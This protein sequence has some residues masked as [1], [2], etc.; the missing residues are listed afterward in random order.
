M[1]KIKYLYSLLAACPATSVLAETPA[2][3]TL[4]PIVVTATRT[5]TKL[6]EVG[7]SITVIN[8][9]ELARR[10]QMPVS[11]ILRG[12]PGLDV[13]RTGGAGQQVSV[14][15]RGTNSN[16]SLVLINGI[17][18]NDPASPGAAFDFANLLTDNIERIEIL[19]GPQ[20]VLYGSDAIG[21]VINIITKKGGGRPQFSLQG[22]GG[23]FDTY[24]FGG[25]ASGGSSLLNYAVS[26]SHLE[27]AGISSATA[28]RG[29]TEHD[30]YRN[31]TVDA[32]FG[33]TPGEH[34]ELDATL[35]YN[36][37]HVELDGS[38]A[39]GQ[40]TDDPNA[41]QDAEQ[42]FARGQARLNLF[43]DRWQQILGLSYT[44]HDRRNRDALDPLTDGAF[45]SRF[46]GEKIKIDWQN[47]VKLHPTNTLSFGIESEEERAASSSQFLSSF[48]NSSSEL[49]EKSVTTTGYF[50]QDQIRLQDRFFLTGGVRVDDHG[51]FGAQVTW[52]VVPSIVIAE[53]GTKLKASY[54]TGF[55]APSLFQLFDPFSGN[56]DLK[57]E[58]SE[59]W[60]VGFEQSLWDKRMSFGSTYFHIDFDNLI[61]FGPAPN[62]RSLNIGRARS[63]G[64]ESFI[65]FRPLQDLSLRLDHTWMDAEDQ[66][67]DQALLRRPRHKLGFNLSY[68]FL[69]KGD[70]SLTVNHVGTRA[71]I[72]GF[73]PATFA[74]LRVRLPSYT[75]VNIAAS[76]DI[77]KM[78]RI[79]GRIENLSNETYQEAAGFGAPGVAGFGGVRL[80]F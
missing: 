15:L 54:G 77:N 36:N 26:A 66:D 10:Q 9:E 80:S 78:L 65:A 34:F 53:T 55:K 43:Q 70:V 74:A 71:D 13:V 44:R 32:R 51:L 52:R 41:T 59:G 16:H 14:F 35:R 27:T 21:G 48:G 28:E 75:V 40:L 47:N 24:K 33:L 31:T 30:G 73:D 3:Q 56:R 69:N 57:P 20:S 39:L 38:N 7:S 25:S 72:D 8:S 63:Q 46:A 76:Y 49:P 2:P 18:A 61:A 79:F 1:N 45:P 42:F 64:V 29:N 58:E 50:F 19:R 67:A 5:S 68:R 60:D 23:S 37:T 4:E 17:E 12:V 11:E 22:E 62:F 6:R